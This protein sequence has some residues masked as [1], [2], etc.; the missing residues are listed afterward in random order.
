MKKIIL[1][2]IAPILAV[3]ALA[4]DMAV[5]APPVVPAPTCSLTSCT[6]FFVG[7]IVD[8]SGGNFNLVATGLG[9]IAQNQFATGLRAGWEYWDTKW[10]ARAEIIGM[11]GIA[12]NGNLPGQGNS[13]LWSVGALVKLGY[14]FL[15]QSA[16]SG[17]PILPTGLALISPYAI[18]GDWTRPWGSG[19]AAGAGVEGFIAK[20]LTVSV[21]AIHVN[22]NNALVN[23][24]I[25]QQ[26][27]DL[28]L[29]GMDYHF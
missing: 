23:P 11:Y 26:T 3:P 18:I 9:G 2:A 19:L 24:N 12:Q 10:Y 5:K 1:A 22:Y 27:E 15:G 13:A 16:P 17:G 25:K 28:V 21:D 29:G 20:N 14:N 8:E 7:G 4:A 6:G